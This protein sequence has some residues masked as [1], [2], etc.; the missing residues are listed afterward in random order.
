MAIHND[1][2]EA[3]LG[4]HEDDLVAEYAHLKQG[5]SDMQAYD[6][7]VLATIE[8]RVRNDSPRDRLATYLE[9][10]GILGYTGRIFEIATGQ[11]EG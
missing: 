5:E 3:Y 1:L 7:W 2:V 8:K 10:N 6:Q 9:W 11:F 4:Y